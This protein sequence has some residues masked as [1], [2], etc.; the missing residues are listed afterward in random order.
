MQEIC[1]ARNEGARVQHHLE[2]EGVLEDPN[3]VA[4]DHQGRVIANLFGLKRDIGTLRFQSRPG[5]LY[6]SNT[7]REDWLSMRLW[8]GERLIWSHAGS[9][10]LLQG[11]QIHQLLGPSW[12]LIQGEHT[13]PGHP[14]PGIM[15]P[16]LVDVFDNPLA[17]PREEIFR[18]VRGVVDGSAPT[19]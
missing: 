10:G 9:M 5:Y 3:D 19:I 6:L 17:L 13:L 16:V 8:A 12:L 18:V 15:H 4:I 7:K 14:L 2:A 1:L 11:M